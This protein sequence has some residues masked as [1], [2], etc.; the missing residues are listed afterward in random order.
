MVR[1]KMSLTPLESE[2]QTVALKVEDLYTASN[3]LPTPNY[4]GSHCTIFAY[5]ITG[6]N[7]TIFAYGQTGSGK[8]Y[9]ILGPP[10]CRNE[11]KIT[12]QTGFMHSCTIVMWC[13]ILVNEASMTL[14]RTC[15]LLLR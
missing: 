6:Y 5:E 14:D 8:T 13:T 4:K 15:R 2:S 7:G 1:S 10:G 3:A 12:P 11:E 9:T